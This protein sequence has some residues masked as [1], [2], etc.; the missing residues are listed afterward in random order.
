MTPTLTVGIE[1]WP[2]ARPFTIA[3]GRKDVAVVVVAEIAAGDAVGHGEGVPYPRYGETPDGVAAAIAQQAPA[4]AAGADREALRSLMA[5]GAAR[6]ALDLALWDLQAKLAGRSVA[7]IAGIAAPGRVVTA[8]TIVI[9]T[10]EAMGRAAAALRTRPL[11]KIKL[12]A[13]AVVERVAAVRAAAPLAR[14]IVDANEGWT[15]DLLARV[16]PA[17]A[18]LGVELIEQPVPAAD[19]EALRDSGSPVPLCADESCHTRADLPRL[20]GR[21]QAVNVKL[22]KAGGLTEALDLAMAARAAGFDVMVG[23]MVGTSLAMAP[24]LVLAPLAQWVDLDGPL[25]LARDRQPGLQFADGG[26]EPPPPGLWG[27][28]TAVQARRSS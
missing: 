3:R 5:P 21:Y 12:D 14:L 7:D 2:L 1:H 18:G 19:D 24:A 9:D 13:E 28:A 26:I 15:P 11:L 10:P 25:W 22:D 6:N 27:N 17:L 20:R 8:E 4:I 16:A 23:C